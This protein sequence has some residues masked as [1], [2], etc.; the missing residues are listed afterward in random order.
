VDTLENEI[1]QNIYGVIE[2]IVNVSESTEE[3]AQV[4]QQAYIERNA[5]PRLNTTFQIRQVTNVHKT[6]FQPYEVKAGDVVM[7]SDASIISS[8]FIASDGEAAFTLTGFILNT[9]Y[10]HSSG[11]SSITIGFTDRTV[12]YMMSRWDAARGS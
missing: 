4:I 1:S 8:A 6:L 11:N 9:S 3:V 2:D 5:Y 10:N 7:L 12:E